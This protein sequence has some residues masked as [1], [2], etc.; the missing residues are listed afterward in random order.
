MP[1]CHPGW[2]VAVHDEPFR[3]LVTL[4]IL[5]IVTACSSHS[6]AILGISST[7]EWGEP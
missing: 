3:L 2:G 5:L 1:V 6:R 7:L 4:S